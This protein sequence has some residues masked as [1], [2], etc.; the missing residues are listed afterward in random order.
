MKSFISEDDKEESAIVLPELTIDDIKTP[1]K[2]P[3]ETPKEIILSLIES[4]PKVT[5]QE[6]TETSA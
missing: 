2:T 6:M 4:E 5:V 3:K 1:K